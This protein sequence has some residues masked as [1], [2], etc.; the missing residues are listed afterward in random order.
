MISLL[1][2]C[3]KNIMHLLLTGARLDNLTPYDIMGW[4][5]LKRK[6]ASW[7]KS[8]R[9]LLLNGSVN[10]TWGAARQ[11]QHDTGCFKTMSTWHGV[12][13][14]HDNMTWGVSR[15]CQH[16]TGY[17]KMMLTLGTP[18]PCQHAWSASWPWQHDTGL[19]SSRFLKYCNVFYYYYYYFCWLKY[20]IS[21]N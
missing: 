12:L 8:T 3:A 4:Q 17:F 14:G 1:V 5:I 13:H 15:Q 21:L 6:C 20:L 19:Q 2:W 7:I 16:D 11:Y 10:I 18:R 9:K